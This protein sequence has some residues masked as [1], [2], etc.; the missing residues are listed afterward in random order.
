[1]RQFYQ[2]KPQAMNEIYF[3]NPITLP[4]VISFIYLMSTISVIFLYIRIILYCVLKIPAEILPA[5]VSI[6]LPTE[7]PLGS[8]RPH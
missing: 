7:D 6:Q 3:V 5:Y 8:Q 4:G 1:M 2:T